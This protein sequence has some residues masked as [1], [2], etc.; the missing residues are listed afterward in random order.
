ML[1]DL[2]HNSVQS[3]SSMFSILSVRLNIMINIL[4]AVDFNHRY[5]RNHVSI[6]KPAFRY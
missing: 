6:F 5:H 4:K 2:Y 1:H 3:F